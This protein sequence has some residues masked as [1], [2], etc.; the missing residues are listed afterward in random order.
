MAHCV[1]QRFSAMSL[2]IVAAKKTI[3]KYASLSKGNIVLSEAHSSNVACAHRK[4]APAAGAYQSPP[5]TRAQQRGLGLTQKQC[6]SSFFSIRY[7]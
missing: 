7:S 1:S 5:L 4:R 2:I 6:E 3:K